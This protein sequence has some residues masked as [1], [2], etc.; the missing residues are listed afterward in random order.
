MPTLIE[1]AV[2]ALQLGVE[3]Y[4]ANDPRRAS[5]AARNFFAG[6]LLLAKQA[7]IS[8]APNADERAVIA[9]RIDL[10]PDGQ[11]GVEMVASN[12]TID[13]TNLGPRLRDFGVT[14]D[15]PALRRLAS[16]RNEIEHSSHQHSSEQVR[17]VIARAFPVVVQLFDSI[18]LEPAAVLG[19]AWLGMLQV[20]ELFDREVDACRATFDAI[21][22]D[23]DYLAAVPR[24]CPDCK[25]PM[26]SQTVPTNTDH[27]DMACR[28][29][30]CGETNGG[31]RLVEES[32]AEYLSNDIY[33]AARDGESSPLAACP[34]CGVTAYVDG[35]GCVWCGEVLGECAICGEALTPDTVSWDNSELCAYH[36]N[37]GDR[38]D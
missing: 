32:L 36:A 33:H 16:V 18:E 26:V 35:E 34:E 22:W 13:F 6:I 7:L 5:S 24:I 14:V 38:D 8:K 2:E 19:D 17:E 11:G 3:D 1:N 27:Q 9:A 25:S 21:A 10:R 29:R 15:Q 37:M 30:A 28:C 4:H 12:N 23:G 31:Q 20:R